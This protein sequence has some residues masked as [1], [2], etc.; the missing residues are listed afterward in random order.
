MGSGDYFNDVNFLPASLRYQSL[1]L[2]YW[3]ALVECQ[4]SA[5]AKVALQLL[6]AVFEQCKQRL[7]DLDMARSQI[8]MTRAVVLVASNA[9]SFS[10]ISGHLQVFN[11]Q[12]SGLLGLV[13]YVINHIFSC[14][15]N[16]Q[17]NTLIQC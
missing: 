3:L 14:P 9:I 17:I 5:Y 11:F 13:E 8:M 4:D 7:Q 15:I 6:G 1:A 2:G 12:H 16:V 10:V